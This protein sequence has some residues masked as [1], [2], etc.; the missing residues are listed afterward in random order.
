M[1]PSKATA[2]L[3]DFSLP[4]SPPKTVVIVGATYGVGAAVA[5][6][7]ARI[8]CARIFIMGRSE[9]KAEGVL[10]DLKRNGKD[11]L[12]VAF[13]KGDVSNKKGM[14]K[15]AEDLNIALGTGQID[16]L[17]MCQNGVPSGIIR[18]NDDGEEIAFAIQTLSRFAV[19][20]L[21]IKSHSLAPK[22]K[23]ITI[24]NSGMDFAELST[25]DLSLKERAKTRSKITLTQDQS[26]RD[27]CVLD[28]ITM[29]FNARYPEYSCY[30]I[31][32]GLVKTE[33]FFE[34]NSL[35]FPLST[36]MN[37][38]VRLVGTTPAA[39]SNTPVYVGTQERMGNGKLWQYTMKPSKPGSWAQNDE[40][41]K[42]CW[43]ALKI[44]IGEK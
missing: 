35:P 22:A 24:A 40:N 27:S 5:R 11:Y 21:L 28:T 1:D 41:R 30:N 26:K 37:L 34:N 7:C 25:S 32:P 23:I 6:Q 2:A 20:Y 13:V 31:W 19:P 15:A 18:E 4:P 33:Y 17:F 29:E 16:Y 38:A 14:R 9:D 39:F 10:K 8:G 12:Q 3:K 42:N 36:I 44:M 43:N